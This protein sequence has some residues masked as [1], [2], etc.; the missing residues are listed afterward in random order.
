MSSEEGRR[1]K[2]RG[3]EGLKEGRVKVLE[4]IKDDN[5]FVGR[6]VLNALVDHLAT[7]DA[8]HEVDILIEQLRYGDEA[9]PIAVAHF[10]AVHIA[11]LIKTAK[12]VA[13]LQRGKIR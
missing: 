2:K 13:N 12:F 1:C 11:N 10:L 4:I 6:D 9:N 5:F 7:N 3:I 8:P